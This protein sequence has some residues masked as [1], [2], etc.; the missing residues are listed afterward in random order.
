VAGRTVTGLERPGAETTA[1]DRDATTPMKV[2]TND[3]EADG[4]TRSRVKVGIADY[5]TAVEGE[6]LVTSGLGSCVGIALYDAENGVAGLAH[7]MLPRNDGDEN[8]AK[9][10][11]TG[12]PALLDEMRRSGA[13]PDRVR[14]KMAGGSAMFDFSSADG[15]IGER[16]AAAARHT[17]DRL[18]I[19]L[20]AADVGGDHGRS[21]ALDAAT[22]QLTVRSAN[23]GETTI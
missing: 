3:A 9:Y 17:L 2:Y 8:E 18:G 19:R 6:T 12:V 7:A 23:A 22:G 5:E 4:A 14:A 11:D 10:V 21:L 20:V 16:N 13:D 1:D 15:T